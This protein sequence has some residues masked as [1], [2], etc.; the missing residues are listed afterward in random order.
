MFYDKES[1][2]EMFEISA[3]K[4]N[5]RHILITS[6]LVDMDYDEITSNE[7]VD[8]HRAWKEA[9]KGELDTRDAAYL[10]NQGNIF[11]LVHETH[12]DAFEESIC[13]VAYS[14]PTHKG[15]IRTTVEQLSVK[16]TEFLL[17][18]S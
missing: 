9:V 4:T 8:Y 1:M 12:A 10:I 14:L 3:S 18:L 13:K 17:K 7:V 16:E 2:L 5:W 6:E 11:C 15:S